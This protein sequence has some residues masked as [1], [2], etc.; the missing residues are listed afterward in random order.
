MANSYSNTYRY[1]GQLVLGHDLH[2]D[3]VYVFGGAGTILP[4]TILGR[5]TASGK[6][7]AFATGASD[8]SEAPIGIATYPI[9]AAGA[10]DVAGRMMVSGEV[11][12]NRLIIAA[13]GNGNNI[14]VAQLDALRA[15]GIVPIDVQVVGENPA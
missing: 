7:K 12:R 5:V 1:S 13:D 10:G 11:N 3:E 6:I 2:R 14:T 8:G 15:I 4:G 9:E